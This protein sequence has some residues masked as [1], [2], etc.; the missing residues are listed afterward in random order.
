[1]TGRIDDYP[2]RIYVSSQTDPNAEYLV[3][4]CAYPVGRM[5]DG[6][7]IFN[8]SCGDPHQP[9]TMCKH[10]RYKCNP[11]MK[12]PGNTRICRCAHIKWALDNAIIWLLPVM[13]K[14]DPNKRQRE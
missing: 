3:D 11:V 9:E 8:G 6:T 1:M 14:S 13:Q 5:P 2:T 7:P 12:T 4:L 10:F